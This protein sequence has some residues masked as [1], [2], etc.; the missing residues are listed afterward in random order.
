MA[1]TKLVRVPAV[2]DGQVRVYFLEGR[3][4]GDPGHGGLIARIG[5]RDLLL[6]HPADRLIKRRWLNAMP[7]WFRDDAGLHTW[8][9][10]CLKSN[11]A[12]H[13]EAAPAYRGDTCLCAGPD[14]PHEMLLTFPLSLA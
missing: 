11:W 8:L 5:G 9:R 10:E 4:K 13:A 3:V 7:L 6:S 14:I 2:V 1:P 12:T